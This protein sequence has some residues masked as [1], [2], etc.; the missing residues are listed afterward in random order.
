MNMQVK[1]KDIFV[2]ITYTELK[3]LIIKANQRDILVELLKDDKEYQKIKNAF[4]GTANT[5]QKPK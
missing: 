1:S 2:E 5:K 4:D 3:D